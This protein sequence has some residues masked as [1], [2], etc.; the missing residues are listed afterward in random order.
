MKKRILSNEEITMLAQKTEAFCIKG[1]ETSTCGYNVTSIN[2]Q[3]STIQAAV[4]RPRS[5]Y[6]YNVHE[7][8]EGAPN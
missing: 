8:G 3:H 7:W 6:R 2:S 1:Q 5:S 4:D